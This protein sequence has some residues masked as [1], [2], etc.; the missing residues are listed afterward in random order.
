V[1]EAALKLNP[2]RGTIALALSLGLAHIASALVLC[3]MPD[4]SKFIGDN[5]PASCRSIADPVLSEVQTL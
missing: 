2:M 1:V 5:P 3:T 4:G